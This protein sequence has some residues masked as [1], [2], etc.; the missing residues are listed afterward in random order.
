MVCSNLIFGTGHDFP[1]WK[2]HIII[3]V[4]NRPKIINTSFER[5]ISKIIVIEP[6]ELYALFNAGCFCTQRQPVFESNKVIIA[7]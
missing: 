4:K 6:T 7:L 5:P 2:D 3:L 1:F